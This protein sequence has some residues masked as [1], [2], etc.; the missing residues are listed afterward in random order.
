MGE[1][2]IDE[3]ND[4]M[5]GTRLLHNENKNI[6][7]RLDVIAKRQEMKMKQIELDNQYQNQLMQ[8]E[9]SSSHSSPPPPPPF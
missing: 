9:A 3:F 6:M 1:M 4:Y 8:Y 2:W 5:R 7:A